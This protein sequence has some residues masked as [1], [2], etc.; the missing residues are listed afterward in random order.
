MGRV[1]WGGDEMAKSHDPRPPYLGHPQG[2]IPEARTPLP[3]TLPIQ[4]SEVL[5]SSPLS[6]PY[7]APDNTPMPVGPA[8]VDPAPTHTRGRRGGCAAPGLTGG[9]VH[10]VLS[11]PIGGGARGV[12]SENCKMDQKGSNT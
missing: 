5:A 3:Y 12:A 8:E 2:A 7:I 9:T 4:P 6:P 1:R 10:G 11:Y